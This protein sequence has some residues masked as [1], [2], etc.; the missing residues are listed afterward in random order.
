MP[1]IYI[2]CRG[3]GC[4]LAKPLYHDFCQRCD[5]KYEWKTCE[6]GEKGVRKVPTPPVWTCLDCTDRKDGK[7]LRI[8]RGYGGG[9]CF[10][11]DCKNKISKNY[12]GTRGQCWY[13]LKHKIQHT[14]RKIW[15]Y[16]IH[17][18]R[19]SQKNKR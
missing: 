4:T 5:G 14:K 18:A 3:H 19:I 7:P 1:K 16:L 10:T 2:R 13:C 15:T 17:Q 11:D 6:C 12:K 9:Q 8:I